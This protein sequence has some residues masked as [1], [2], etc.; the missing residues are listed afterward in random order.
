MKISNS[1]RQAILTGKEM[2]IVWRNS[3]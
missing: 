2:A 1:S 3:D